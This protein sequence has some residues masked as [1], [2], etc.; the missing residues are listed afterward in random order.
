MTKLS[1]LE[2]YLLIFFFIREFLIHIPR[3]LDLICLFNSTVF[4]LVT[5][6]L[7]SL[8][9]FLQIC[10]I[11]AITISKG[12]E[13]DSISRFT[14]LVTASVASNYTRIEYTTGP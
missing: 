2:D 10:Y 12:Q 1:L 13:F 3:R 14:V 5:L 11:K 4:I 7:K 9:V 8:L 6:I